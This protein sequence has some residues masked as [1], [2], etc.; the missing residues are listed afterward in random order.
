MVQVARPASVGAHG[1]EQRIVWRQ[2]PRRPK[3][4]SP[5]ILALVRH[6]LTPT[7]GKQMPERGPGPSLSED[8]IAQA[9][10]AALH[11]AAWRAQWPAIAALYSS[12]LRRTRETAGLLAKYLDREV[13][14]VPELADCDAG[15]WAGQELKHLA[16]RPEWATVVHHPSDFCFPGGEALAGMASR[17]VGA[18]KRLAGAHPG[19]TV[20]AVSHADPIKAVLADALGMHLDMFQRVLVSPASVSVISYSASGAQVLEANWTGPPPPAERPGKEPG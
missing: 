1:H 6:G 14:E 16:K 18:A 5:T 19:A 11:I 3:P 7:T 15:D 20:V 9:E 17:V 13:V 2:M 8:G 4:A 10:Q 12:P